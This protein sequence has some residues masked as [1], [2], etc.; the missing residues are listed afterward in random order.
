MYIQNISE[1]GRLLAWTGHTA[2]Y[3]SNW[4]VWR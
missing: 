2:V 1:W 3:I 4:V